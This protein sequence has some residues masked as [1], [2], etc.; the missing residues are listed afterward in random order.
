MKAIK[1]DIIELIEKIAERIREL[2]ERKN[3]DISPGTKT[4][5][6]AK[7]DG[8]GKYQQDLQNILNEMC[9]DEECKD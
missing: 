9:E 2:S 1:R 7:I 4:R 5:L 8:L 6:F 3:W